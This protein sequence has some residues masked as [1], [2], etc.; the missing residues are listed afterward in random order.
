VAEGRSDEL[1]RRIAGDVVT[2]DVEQ[3]DRARAGGLP[4]VRE[5]ALTGSTVRLT[6]EQGDRAVL[7]LLRRLDDAGSGWPHSARPG[8]P[9]TTSC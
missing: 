5:V 3:P 2:L 6:V 7:P 1:K 9:S 8:R 4:D